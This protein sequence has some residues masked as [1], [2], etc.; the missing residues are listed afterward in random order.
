MSIKVKPDFYKKKVPDYKKL[1]SYI[2]QIHLALS[3]NSN[4][5]L[6]IGKGEGFVSS[7][8]KRYCEQLI[9]ADFNEKLQPDIL[10]DISQKNG[11]LQFKDNSF[12][13]VII[14][15]VLEHVP[16][17]LLDSIMKSLHRI[18]QKYVV[19]SI[20][21]QSNYLFIK[22]IQKGFERKIF[23]PYLLL[24]KVFIFITNKFNN[25]ISNLHY[26]FVRKKKR[27]QFNG[28]HYWELGINSYNKDLFQKTVRRYFIIEKENRLLQNPYHHFFLLKKKKIDHKIDSK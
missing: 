4:K 17:D 19:I 12:D 27:F 14:C 18:T 5:I 22:L 25:L 10:L 15:E 24:L 6:E 3:T 13:L 26:K 8:L 21:N 28:E 16:F 9:T 20:P 1:Q 11:F 23:Y 7:V 2:M